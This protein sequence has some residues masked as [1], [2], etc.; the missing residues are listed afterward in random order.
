MLTQPVAANFS[1]EC[2]DLLQHHF[3]QLRIDSSIS[4]EVI[5]ER[6]YC[7]A[8]EWLQL[9]GLL[10]K[11]NQKRIPCFPALVIPQY[12][13]SGDRIHSVLRWDSPRLDWN[14]HPIK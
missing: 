4:L 7:S 13:R 14:G 11:G 1:V 8:T 12:D 5:R 3:D 9:E 6:G 2:P 10:F